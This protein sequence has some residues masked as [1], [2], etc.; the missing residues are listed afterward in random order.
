MG[1]SL[2]GEL[3]LKRIPPEITFDPLFTLLFLQI[4]LKFERTT[5]TRALKENRSPQFKELRCQPLFPKYMLTSGIVCRELTWRALVEFLNHPLICSWTWLSACGLSNQFSHVLFK[6]VCACP[7]W[8][9]GHRDPHSLSL[10]QAFKSGVTSMRRKTPQSTPRDSHERTQWSHLLLENF[11]LLVFPRDCSFLT[12][13]LS[14]ML[15]HPLIPIT[16]WQSLPF[17]CHLIQILVHAVN[18]RS[19]RFLEMFV[20]PRRGQHAKKLFQRV[21]RGNRKTSLACMERWLDPHYHSLSFFLHLTFQLGCILWETV[22]GSA[23]LEKPS[24]ILHDC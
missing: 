13:T 7:C 24:L 2:S 22:R 3:P 21:R 15:C 11:Y 8:F 19:M 1:S 4:L 9:L 16:E 17:I 23:D 20:F 18:I 12:L 14:S 10:H 6:G 5:P